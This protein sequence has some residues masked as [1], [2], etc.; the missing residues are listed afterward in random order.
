MIRK[1]KTIFNLVS[2]M[3]IRYIFF[4]IWYIIKTKI[5]YQKKAF[6][7]NLEFKKYIS[8]K[9]WNDNLPLF[10]FYGKEIN[11]LVKKPKRDLKKNIEDYKKGI[12][13]FF[14]KT[15]IDLGI[16]Y[17]WI[18][19]PIT[20]FKY[21]INK[22]WSEIKDLSKEEGDIKYV[23]EKARFS[24]LYDV[25]RYDYHFEDDQSKYVLDIIIDFIDNN[26]INQGP[27]Y[28]CSQEISLRVLNWTF[29]LYYYKDSSNLTEAIFQKIM[30]IIYWQI[31]HVY[32]NINFSRITV[33][34][35]HALTETLLLYLS[36]KLFP[37]FP[38]VKEWSI[39]GKNWFEKEIA[40]QIYEDGTFLQFSTNYHRLAL[41]LLTWGIQLAKLNNEKFTDIVYQRAQKSLYFLD[42]CSDP[43]TGK[44][45]N[46]GSNDGAL[47]FKL[48]NDDYRDYRSQLDDLRAVLNGYTYFY[49]T[50]SLWLGIQPK[51]KKQPLL[52]EINTFE[53]SGYYI[54][55]DGNTKTFIRCGSYKDRPFQSDNLH[56]D[57]WVNG[58]NY[59]RDTGS[60]K[61][62]SNLVDVNY[63]NG[64]EGHNTVSIDKA[65][66]M[67]KGERFM[68]YY[69]INKAKA[70][71]KKENNTFQFEGSINAFKHI[72]DN[73]Q[74]SRKVVKL[75]G[76]NSWRI[77]DVIQN[78]GNRKIY[79][80]WH[81][82]PD[83]L[84]SIEIRTINEDGKQITPVIEEKW[85]SSYYGVKEKSVRLTFISEKNVL[86][87]TIRIK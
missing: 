56:I 62:N 73:I 42:A 4:R 43:V 72:E 52:S 21:D 19:N 50:S 83:Y 44:L 1:A 86:D 13:I 80:Y 29:A 63:F 39:K 49:S 85:F 15:K 67:L 9:E 59:L 33:R 14:N 30:H 17:D 20:N 36:G 77:S 6:P 60:Y 32:N 31:H 12:F 65:D 64:V 70:T 81:L 3:G 47:F 10:F 18:T 5:G 69:W 34:N 68:W 23:W 22:H 84:N 46:Y 28:K 55:Q 48:T 37:F 78:K 16:D 41:Q 57:I 11:T 38:N 58:I 87:T 7:T 51:Q 45:P 75:Q 82:H 54:S 25:I 24:F 40:Y 79:Q 35:N 2:N 8:L 53:K 76:E 27:N 74:H 26:P 61:Y 66:Q 71:L